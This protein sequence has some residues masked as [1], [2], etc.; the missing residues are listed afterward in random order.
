[1]EYRTKEI[2]MLEGTRRGNP[3]ACA[4]FGE[5][6]A[7]DTRRFHQSIPAYAPS[8]LVALDC[9]A[10]RCGVKGIYV[11]DES[12]R[13]G[14]KAFKGLG[15]SYAMFRILCDRFGLDPAT[16]DL[17]DFQK[18]EIRRRCA[19]IRF[20]TATDGNHGKG[21]SWAARLFGCEANVYLPAGTVE[22]RRKAIEE[23]GNAKA[24]ITAFSYDRTVAY[25][26]KQA[27]ENGWILIQDTSWDGYEQYPKWIIDGYLTLGAEAVEQ[28][29]GEAPTHVFLQAGV[30]AMAGGILAYLHNRYPQ[31]PPIAVIAEPTQAACIYESVR[32]GD[33]EPHTVRDDGSTIM[34]GLNCQTPC[35]VIWPILRDCAAFFCACEDSVAERGMRAYANPIGDD[36]P[37]VS[38]ESGSVTLG[39]L[40]GILER[41][42]LKNLLRLGKDSVILL[43]NTEGDTDPE[44]YRRVVGAQNADAQQKC[45]EGV[46]E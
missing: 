11:K 13:F 20:V 42:D 19:A 36:E 28:L 9:L 29:G 46:A 45:E 1:M 39:L 30:G 43:L 8:R 4:A 31:A 7:R 38:G 27:E 15:G 33:G 21:V 5:R 41:D 3:R 12:T 10:R 32:I 34:A 44:G 2:R 22:A 6:E 40:L 24:E 17:R 35:G 37:I 26:A 25:A 14:L 18:A 23:A 16:A